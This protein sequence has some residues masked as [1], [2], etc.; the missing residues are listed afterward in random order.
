MGRNHVHFAIGYPGEE[1]V[2]SGMRATCKK[3]LIHYF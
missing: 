1:G 2:I 3:N